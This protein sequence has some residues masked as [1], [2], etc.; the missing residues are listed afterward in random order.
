[1]SSRNQNFRC[2]TPWQKLSTQA[3]KSLTMLVLSTACLLSISSAF[4][5]EKIGNISASQGSSVIV[6]GNN[7]IP[8]ASGLEI[9]TGDFIR[10]S[11]NAS[12]GVMF[13][14]GTRVLVGPTSQVSIDTYAFNP[15][16]QKGN[17]LVGVVKGTMRM[18]SG[19]ITKA[20]PGQAVIKTATATAGLRGTDVI[21]EVP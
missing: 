20:N 15:A 18:I 10:T 9:K 19:L 1:M 8:V 21:V 3:K 2:Q 16:D 13:I 17:M 7:N 11:E 6:R 4:A 12:V 5:Q 14:D